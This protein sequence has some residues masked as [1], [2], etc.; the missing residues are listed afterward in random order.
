MK[1][2]RTQPA[3]EMFSHIVVLDDKQ[4][5]VMLPSFRHQ[6]KISMIVNPVFSKSGKW[7]NSILKNQTEKHKKMS[8]TVHMKPKL[9]TYLKGGKIDGL[10]PKSPPN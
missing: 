9:Q 5:M 6:N 3:F 7:L 2:K 4:N 10:A 1:I 8:Q